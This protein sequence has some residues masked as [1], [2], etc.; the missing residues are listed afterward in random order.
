[1][2]QKDDG[3]G[4]YRVN[5]Y[6]DGKCKS[7]LVSRLVAMAFIQNPDGFLV[8]GHMDDNKK[9]NCVSNLYWTTTKENNYHNGKLKRFHM[10]HNEKIDQIANALSTP[11]IS[12]DLK[13]GE[14][15]LFKS[16]QEASRITK[17]NSGKISMCCNGIRKKHCGKTW[18]FA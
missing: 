1:M 16:M 5:L 14:E 3:K 9:N 12:Y 15:Q 17:A 7:E 8:V 4:Y 18:R 13:T 6:K 2:R 11:V 10:A